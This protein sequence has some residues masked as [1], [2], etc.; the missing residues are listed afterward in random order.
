MTRRRF[1]TACGIFISLKTSASEY[2]N[3][4]SQVQYINVVEI[5]TPPSALRLNLSGISQLAAAVSSHVP[6]SAAS[7]SRSIDLHGMMNRRAGRVGPVARGVGR[8]GRRGRCTGC[9]FRVL[10]TPRPVLVIRMFL[11][12][13]DPQP[14][15]LLDVGP[16][17]L[18]RQSSPFLSCEKPVQSKPSSKRQV[19][20]DAGERERNLERSACKMIKWHT[21]YAELSLPS[22]RNS[23]CAA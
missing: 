18:R 15:G 4:K 11:H 8:R 23:L 7:T 19:T 1:I 12:V 10:P 17:V 16:P 3:V 6:S 20:R 22:F 13:Y 2:A 5:I 9:P 14:L 21:V